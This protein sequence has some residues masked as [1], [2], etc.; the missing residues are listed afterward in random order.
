LLYPYRAQV[1]QYVGDEI[2]VMW[3]EKEGLFQLRCIE[4]FFECK[5]RMKSKKDYYNATY[6]LVPE[7]KAGLHTGK[8]TAIEIGQVK[9]DIA[10]H[11]DTVNTAARIQSICNELNSDFLVSDYLLSKVE[12]HPKIQINSCGEVVLRGKKEPIGISSLSLV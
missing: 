7:F 11:G 6:G 8:V 5:Q 1:Y 10:Y 12:L 9:M 2:V 3:P 4:F